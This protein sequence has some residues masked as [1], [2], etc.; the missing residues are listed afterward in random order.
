MMLG[1]AGFAFLGIGCFVWWL[2][3]AAI[4]VLWRWFLPGWWWIVPLLLGC[5]HP[6]L[7]AGWLDPEES[8][9]FEGLAGPV[10]LFGNLGCR[11]W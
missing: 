10:R 9:W 6:A 3:L 5:L 7:L 4:C 2:C 8:W 11:L 1:V